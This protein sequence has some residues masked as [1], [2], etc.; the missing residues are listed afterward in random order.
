MALDVT[1]APS[2]GR[3]VLFTNGGFGA[4]PYGFDAIDWR[5][6][7]L[8]SG[9]GQAG[10]FEDTAW[11]VTEKAGGTNM[12][13]DVA[14]N[15]GMLAV[16]NDALLVPQD[17][18]Y[19]A[20]HSAVINLSTITTNP[21]SNPRKDYIV[22]QVRNQDHDGSGSYDARV[23]Y[24]VGTATSG[25][26]HDNTLGAPTVPDTSEIL[27]QVLVP[28]ATTTAITNAMIRDRRPWARGALGRVVRTAGTVTIATTGFQSIDA[29]NL[30]R[31]YELSGTPVMLTLIA[32]MSANASGT[33]VGGSGVA[34]N[35]AM[36]ITSDGG[37]TQLQGAGAVPD[38]SL[39]QENAGFSILWVPPAAGS[40]TLEPW[41]TAN[42]P[43]IVQVIATATQPVVF[44]VQELDRSVANNGTT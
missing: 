24:L 28:P 38:G 10:V 32:T 37:I 41:F 36:T 34:V 14:A 15:V 22:G 26:T 33:P 16:R 2:A 42:Q 25:A 44:T 39:F 9:A 27:A 3:P 31:R 40:Y 23:R 30:L 21:G 11:K 6:M 13:V 1:I 43:A 7:M 18:Y 29:T 4:E 17:L 19:V 8:C 5:R 35:G 12:S 20:P